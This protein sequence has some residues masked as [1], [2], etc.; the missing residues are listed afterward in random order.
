MTTAAH[1]IG[2]T[3]PARIPEWRRFIPDLRL[4]LDNLLLH[5]LRSLLTMLGM[6]FGVAAVVSMLS[7]G[8]GAQQKVMA[9]IEQLGVRNL[10]IEAKES[11]DYD[12]H[13]KI[14]RTSPGLTFQDYRVI[15]ANLGGIVAS[16]PRKRF[17]PSKVFPKPQMDLPVLFGVEPSYV[18]IAGL[19]AVDGRFFD[20]EENREARPICVL[21]EGAKASLFGPTAAVGQY[22][23]V[24]EQWLHVVGVVG[25]QLSPGADVAG[26][27]SQDLNNLIYVPLLTAIS[28]LEDNKSELHDEIDGIYLRMAD[29]ALIPGSA[30]LV[31]GILNASHRG[32]PDFSVIVPA[33]LLAEQRRTERLFNIVMVAI[34]SISLLVGGIGIMNI[35][36][37]SIM[38]RTRE[39]GV[40]RAVGARRKDI[41]RQFVIEATM[42]SFVGGLLGILFGFGMSRLIAWLAGWSTIVTVASIFLAFL[43]SVSVGMVFGIYPAVKAAR[44]DPVEAIRYE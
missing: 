41:V 15:Q 19:R 33:E 25:P 18:R 42:I 6:I 40:R 3:R 21:G 14:R 36:L 4:G 39:I 1:V 29:A 9:F 7:I 26:L 28:R 17:I 30:E 27:S 34:A 10:I 20:A 31:R 5:K 11:T 2:G 32:A 22:V 24:D 16:T 35:M 43:V 12:T 13:N 38:E 8:A 44:L 23:K 37:A